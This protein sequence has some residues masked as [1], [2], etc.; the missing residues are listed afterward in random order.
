MHTQV[1]FLGENDMI[2]Q[3]CN[4]AKYSKEM[5]TE[6][7]LIETQISSLEEQY[8]EIISRKQNTNAK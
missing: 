1:D 7:E 2:S 5:I 3:L 6:M 8:K 4:S